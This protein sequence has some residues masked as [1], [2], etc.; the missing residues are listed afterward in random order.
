M[1]WLGDMPAPVLA[2]LAVNAFFVLTAIVHVVLRT[3]ERRR[4]D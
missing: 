1:S 2:I 4:K 3:I